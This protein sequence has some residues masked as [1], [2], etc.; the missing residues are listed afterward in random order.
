MLRLWHSPTGWPSANRSGAGGRPTVAWRVPDRLRLRARDQDML[1]S[2]RISIGPR[3]VRWI[4]RTPVQTF[5]LCPLAVMVFE[6]ALHHG[7]RSVV[8]LGAPLLIWGYLQYWWVG[9]YR[10]SLAGGSPGMD[11]LPEHIISR[12]PYRFTRNPRA[13][14]LLARSRADILVVVRVD[15]PRQSRLLVSPACAARRKAA[16]R[17]FWS[18]IRGVSSAGEEMDSGD[19]LTSWM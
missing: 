3:I 2:T 4:G 13:S 14:R 18:R 11:V 9:R 5:V 7:V 8:P 1:Q 6:L 12:G 16:R 10:L 19:S 17:N 15:H